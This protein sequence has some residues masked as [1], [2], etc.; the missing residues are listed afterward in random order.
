VQGNTFTA[1]SESEPNSLVTGAKG[2]VLDPNSGDSSFAQFS[3]YSI[4]GNS[5]NN[6][7]PI[8]INVST[9]GTGLQTGQGNVYNPVTALSQSFN[10]FVTGGSG[11]D[12]LTGTTSTDFI[13]GGA[14]SDSL[15][16]GNA[17]DAFAFTTT[18][19]AT[20][21]DTITDWKVGSG[22]TGDRI[23][24]DDAIFTPLLLGGFGTGAANAGK[25]YSGA[26][27]GTSGIINFNT[28]T[29]SLFY[30][31]SDL[32]RFSGTGVVKICDLQAAATNILATDL[33]VF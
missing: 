23:W 17:A 24:L 26:S 10:S 13:N 8:T 21:I 32:G 11:A 14:G 31:P 22:S 9:G 4:G 28:S 2:I 16:G 20:N 15:T 7:V 1:T 12:T 29:K 5:Y 19:S 25:F 33:I 3:T 30:D 18:P 6:V 27:A